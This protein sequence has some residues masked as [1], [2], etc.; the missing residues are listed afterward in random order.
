MAVMVVASTL[1]ASCIKENPS[2]CN[3]GVQLRCSYLLNPQGENLFENEVSN[4]TVYVF[5]AADRYYGT[6][7][8]G[9]N[10]LTND[11]VM[12]L[13]LPEGTYTLLTWGGDM[14]PYKAVSTTSE[15]AEGALIKGQTTL[16]QFSLTLKQQE[17]NEKLG[18]YYGIAKRVELEA[19][20][21]NVYPIELIKNSKTIRVNF[22]GIPTIAQ[23]KADQAS[24]YDVV[25]T[26]ANGVYKY[27]NTIPTATKMVQYR[28]HTTTESPTGLTYD[29]NTLRLM[30]GQSPMLRVVNSQTGAE[31]CN[32]NI[33][34]AIMRDPKYAT[35][36][37]IDREDLFQF[38]FRVNDDLSISITINGWAIIDVIPEL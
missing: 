5:D 3:P 36:K 10:H 9:G 23:S 16:E 22:T 21:V 28:P 37:D 31:V 7:T 8:D 26:A 4:L 13:P 24:Q 14:T 15:N 32:F 18:L 6:Y 29:S 2:G 27:D 30:I 35:Q 25:I 33:V 17:S 1:L 20:D 19:G 11:Y 34:E 12:T 38:D